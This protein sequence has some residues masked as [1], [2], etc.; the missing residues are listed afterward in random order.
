MNF[1]EHIKNINNSKTKIT[2]NELINF[3]WLLIVQNEIINI[4]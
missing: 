4:I 2:K 3:D 1:I